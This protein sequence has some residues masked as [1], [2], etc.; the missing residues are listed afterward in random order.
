M[1]EHLLF[2]KHI[3]SVLSSRPHGDQCFMSRYA[4]LY[5]STSGDEPFFFFCIGCMLVQKHVKPKS[6]RGL[7][8]CPIL[9]HQEDVCR[10][11]E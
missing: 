3:S 8:L 6:V 11:F 7:V 5:S 9:T 2:T 10:G 4:V 1:P